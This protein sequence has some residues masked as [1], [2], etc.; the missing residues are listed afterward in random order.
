MPV[1]KSFVNFPLTQTGRYFL[2]F[3]FCFIIN[4]IYS[5]QV[6]SLNEESDKISNLPFLFQHDS[7]FAT[8]FNPSL[9]EYSIFEDYN[10]ITSY[11]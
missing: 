10:H 1:T 6:Y 5:F 4:L 11:K 2:T 8:F 3:M 9:G 7:I